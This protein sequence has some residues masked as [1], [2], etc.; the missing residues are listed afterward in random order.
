MVSAIMSVQFGVTVKE[1]SPGAPMMRATSAVLQS[2][3]ERASASIDGLSHWLVA[4]NVG[5][6]KTTV[7]EI[8]RRNSS[9]H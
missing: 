4:P 6:S 5:L 7:M 2:C 3:P 8:V 9:E 1:I